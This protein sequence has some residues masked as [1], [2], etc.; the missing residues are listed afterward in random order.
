MPGPG[1]CLSLLPRPVEAP[2]IG[3]FT[4]WTAFNG[5]PASRAAVMASSRSFRI[6]LW[7]IAGHPDPLPHARK[8]GNHAGARPGLP[9]PRRTL[10]GQHPVIEALAEPGG[11]ARRRP[12]LPRAAALSAASAGG[13]A[14]SGAGRARRDTGPRRP[15]RA[16]Q[17]LRRAGAARCPPGGEE[18]ARSPSRQKGG[19]RLMRRFSRYPGCTLPGQAPALSPACLRRSRATRLPCRTPLP[20]AGKC[21]DGPGIGNSHPVLGRT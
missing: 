7:L 11:R 20:A 5:T 18:R 1:R 2:P 15:H 14:S 17:C 4:L 3:L 16:L 10:D 19:S 12:P 9:C 6:T 8:C 13:E 21:S